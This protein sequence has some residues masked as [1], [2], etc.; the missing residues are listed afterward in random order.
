MLH[1][2]SEA[3]ADGEVRSP[4]HEIL[5]PWKLNGYNS[6]SVINTLLQA[7]HVLHW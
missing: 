7:R 4:I 5:L 2:K 3:Q 1:I 6:G